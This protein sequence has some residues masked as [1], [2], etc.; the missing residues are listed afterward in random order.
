MMFCRAALLLPI[1]GNGWDTAAAAGGAQTTRTRKIKKLALLRYGMKQSSFKAP[2][3]AEVSPWLAGWLAAWLTQW[4]ES[5]KTRSW[6]AQR[7]HVAVHWGAIHNILAWNWKLNR[8]FAV[9]LNDYDLCACSG[10]SASS[11]TT[12]STT[13]YKCKNLG[14]GSVYISCTL[15]VLHSTIRANY[16]HVPVPM[17]SVLHCWAAAGLVHRALHHLFVALNR[18]SFTR[19][20]TIWQHFCLCWTI[21]GIRSSKQQADKRYMCCWWWQKQMQI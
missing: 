1:H 20:T 12:T 18:R 2:T 19:S 17:V 13:S 3:N 15:C 5:P 11:A 10:G 21:A 8:L 9:A 16:T 6:P 4:R 7:R 14:W